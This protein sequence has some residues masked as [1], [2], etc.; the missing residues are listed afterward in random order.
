MKASAGSAPGWRRCAAVLLLLAGWLVELIGIILSAPL[1]PTCGA[2]SWL[3]SL[4]QLLGDRL[5]S[6]TRRA[7]GH[8]RGVERAR[9]EACARSLR[10]P[11]LGQRW[12]IEISRPAVGQHL[13]RTLVSALGRSERERER[14]LIDSETVW[15]ARREKSRALGGRRRK[16]RVGPKEGGRATASRP[17]HFGA[18]KD[19]VARAQSHLLLSIALCVLLSLPGQ[20]QRSGSAERVYSVR[21][22]AQHK[23]TRNGE[24]V[25]VCVCVPA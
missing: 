20:L 4:G 6:C 2:G 10:G 14:Q 8:W 15:S 13:G 5:A 18:P 12:P 22:R 24:R 7:A 3:K 19:V 9:P 23:H 17:T 16:W 1:E 21:V 11:K 25:C